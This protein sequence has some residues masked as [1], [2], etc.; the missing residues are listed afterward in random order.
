MCGSLI[1]ATRDIKRRR[2]AKRFLIT[3]LRQPRILRAEQSKNSIDLQGG[4]GMARNKVQ[5]QKGLSEAAVRRFVWDRTALPC[6]AGRMALAGRLRVSGLP[7]PE[8]LHCQAWDAATVPMQHVPQADVGQG[9]NDFRLQQVAAAPLV[10][11]H[12]SDDP[13]QEGHFQHRTRL[14]GSASPRQRPG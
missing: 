5:F 1:P 11:G 3:R 6:G 12:L 9:R 7:R 14:A 2:G 13:I 8:A 4:F 10:Q